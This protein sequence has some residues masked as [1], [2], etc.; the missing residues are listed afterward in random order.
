MHKGFFH[1]APLSLL[2]WGHYEKSP[3][4]SEANEGFCF[5]TCLMEDGREAILPT[6]RVIG[7]AVR[8]PIKLIAGS[9]RLI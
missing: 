4:V 2:K 8:M 3:L 5:E 9:L 6:R 7:M 1:S